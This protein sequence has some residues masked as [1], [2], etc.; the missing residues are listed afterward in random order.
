MFEI[1]LEVTGAITWAALIYYFFLRHVINGLLDA[2]TK[3]LWLIR[4]DFRDPRNCVQEVTKHYSTW[5]KLWMVPEVFVLRFIRGFKNS[6][7]WG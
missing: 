6:L 7:D 3:S 5:D 2:C 1:I 4:V